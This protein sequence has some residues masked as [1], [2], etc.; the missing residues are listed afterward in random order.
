MNHDNDQAH[1][2]AA[3]TGEQS[4]PVPLVDRVRAAMAE[5][6]QDYARR[7]REV[8]QRLEAARAGVAELEQEAA[9]I[10]RD[11]EQARQEAA[12][13]LGGRPG[14]STPKRSRRAS[15]PPVTDQILHLLAEHEGRMGGSEL[16]RALESRGVRRST[17]NQSRGKL[18]KRGLLF[19][20]GEAHGTQAAVYGLT[21]AGWQKVHE[22]GGAGT[23]GG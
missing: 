4:G 15:G 16:F 14:P 6:E 21:E 3:D 11:W 2:D 23:A 1:P 13:L 22:G 8:E 12:K 19:K 18:L 17:I 7:R 5:A 10:E 9:T 20:D